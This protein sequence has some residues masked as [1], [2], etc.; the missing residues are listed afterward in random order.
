MSATTLMI[1]GKK[2]S[3]DIDP[4]MP[5]LWAIRDVV[6]LKGTKFGCGIAQCGACTVHLNGNATRSCVLPVSAAA[7][8]KI[9]T[10]E[11]LGDEAHLHAVQQA[12]IDE[13]V[14]N[15]A[16]ASRGKLCWQRPCSKQW[17]R[18]TV[19]TQAMPTLMPP[20]RAT[21]AVVSPTY[22]SERPFTVR[23]MLAQHTKPK[24][25][26]EENNILIYTNFTFSP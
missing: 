21:F 25:P 13:Q 11:G 19:P 23:H 1:N 4:Q 8:Q 14:R 3:F 12:W 5:L 20:C 2:H 18:P 9:T 24:P 6:G 15:V 26:Q 16:I 17:Q 10:I 7:G 22:A